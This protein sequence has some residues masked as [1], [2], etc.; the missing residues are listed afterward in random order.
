MSQG[1]NTAEPARSVSF[2]VEPH[3]P[4][5]VIAILDGKPYRILVVFEVKAVTYTGK[6][7]PLDG[8]ALPLLPAFDVQMSYAATQAKPIT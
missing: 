1:D 6:Q 2:G 7:V 4:I 8:D 3:A 5:A